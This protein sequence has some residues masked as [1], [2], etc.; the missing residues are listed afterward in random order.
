MVTPE[1]CL[2]LRSDRMTAPLLAIVN[3]ETVQVLTGD[4]SFS[5]A[6]RPAAFKTYTSFTIPGGVQY[7]GFSPEEQRFLYVQ[8]ASSMASLDFDLKAVANH[9]FTSQQSH[10]LHW[11]DRYHFTV[12]GER[13]ID[14]V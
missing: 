5:D 8:N 14:H 2:A 11:I 3:G 1:N 9:T 10:E 12:T 7:I 13:H 6:E 4:L